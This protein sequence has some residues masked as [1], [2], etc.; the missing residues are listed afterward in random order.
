M[1]MQTSETSGLFL[2]VRPTQV[3][4]ALRPTGLKKK[5]IKKETETLNDINCFKV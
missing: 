4:G 3:R 2:F 5:V 1:E